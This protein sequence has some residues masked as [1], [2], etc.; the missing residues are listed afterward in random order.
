[1]IGRL[2]GLL[3]LAAGWLIAAYPPGPEQPL[4]FSHKSHAGTLKLQ[5]K[6]CH[7]APDPGESMTVGAPRVCMVR[8]A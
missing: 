2:L 8:M 4:P 3:I 7:P 1:M 6:M 5:C